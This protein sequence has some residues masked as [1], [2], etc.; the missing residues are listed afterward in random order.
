MNGALAREA[1]GQA[2]LSL[3]IGLLGGDQAVL[4]TNLQMD[5]P[6]VLGPSIFLVAM[7]KSFYP[8]K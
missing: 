4:I 8:C 2:A 1:R 7:V 3:K 6:I 5:L